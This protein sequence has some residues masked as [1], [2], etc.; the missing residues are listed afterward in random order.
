MSL[1]MTPPYPSKGDPM[2]TASVL[3]L[4]V[5][6]LLGTSACHRNERGEGP[7]ERSGKAV[8]NAGEKTSDTVKEGVEKTGEATERAGE[9]MQNK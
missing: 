2:R 9:K 7:M 1:V 5:I 4:S 6:F 8:D 3:A